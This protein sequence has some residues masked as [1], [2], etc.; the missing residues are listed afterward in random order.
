MNP[1]ARIL[2][3]DDTSS[4]RFML[5][6]DLEE[7]GHHAVC[8]AIPETLLESELFG[9]V[10]GA[11]TGAERDREG[12]CGRAQGWALAQCGGKS[13]A[14]RLLQATRKLFY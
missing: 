5:K 8:A 1:S 11:F 6:G 3:A 13:S 2:V 7:A 9:H 4:F 12:K 14:A 10:K